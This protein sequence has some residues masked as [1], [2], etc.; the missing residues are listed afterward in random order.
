[1]KLIIGKIKAFGY[2]YFIL[3]VLMCFITPLAAVLTSDAMGRLTE[4]VSENGIG[5]A[6]RIAVVTCGLYII[7]VIISYIFTYCKGRING[8]VYAALQKRIQNMIF[9]GKLNDAGKTNLYNSV[10]N[11]ADEICRFSSE[12]FPN[13]L[14]QT[15]SLI[16]IMIYILIIDWKITAAYFAAVIL[17]VGIQLVISRIMNRTGE[18]IKRCEAALNGK[19]ANVLKNRIIV[20]CFESE[21]FARALYE[22]EEEEFYRKKLKLSRIAM[23]LK[24][25]GIICGML[26][27]IS[28]CVAGIYMIP[29]GI[30][31]AGTFISVF[32]L[33]RKTVS[34]QLHYVDLIIEAVKTKPAR[35]RISTI[36]AVAEKGETGNEIAGLKN[37]VYAEDIWYRYPEQEA[38]ALS[39]VSMRIRRGSK[40][41]FVGE[42]GSGKS[43]MLKIIA[44]EL[45]AE[46]GMVTAGEAVLT[47]QFPHMFSISVR[48]NVSMGRTLNDIDKIY[49]KLCLKSVIEGLPEGDETVLSENGGN[50]SGGQR[51]RIAIA[52]A[53]AADGGL[54]LFDESFS[55]LDAETAKTVICN[56]LE[57]KKDST[58]IAVIHQNELAGFFDEV[59]EFSDGKAEK[60]R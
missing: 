39:G 24:T 5:G 59:Y 32:Y 20:K 53:A 23:P 52:R 25:A 29:R 35:K 13:I 18:G 37:D 26:P 33:C 30:I 1:V 11:D 28:I 49:E 51:Q 47:R 12:T 8:D 56:L 7:E 27:V 31:S 38:W 14:L 48:D 17:S 60:R 55:A 34:S 6:G 22:D 46:T 15:V 58:I 21:G 9:F 19:L 43:T 2:R 40:V 50:L 54:Y 3:L 4:H 41:A 45:M 10:S 44:G 16:V 57:I 42:S 36:L